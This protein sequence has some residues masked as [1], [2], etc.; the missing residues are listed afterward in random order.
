[1]CPLCF[2]PSFSWFFSIAHMEVKWPILTCSILIKCLEEIRMVK[3][4]VNVFEVCLFLWFSPISFSSTRKFINSRNPKEKC[5]T[6]ESS[7]IWY[8]MP[9]TIGHNN[10]DIFPLSK[11]SFTYPETP[12][13]PCEVIFHIFFGYQNRVKRVRGIYFWFF[14]MENIQKLRYGFKFF[15]KGR[16][17]R[18]SMGLALFYIVLSM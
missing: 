13:D 18:P 10:S 7:S 11:K 8:C 1:M 12:L 16:I 5:S 4:I 15:E 9:Q 14:F 6:E 17:F 2:A 3:D